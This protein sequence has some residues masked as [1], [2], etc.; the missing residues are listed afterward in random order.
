MNRQM[1]RI[2][3]NAG[4]FIMPSGSFY[5]VDSMYLCNVFTGATWGKL[6]DGEI[7]KLEHLWEN[8]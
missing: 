7:E 6:N 1:F 4:E 5:I 3:T 8:N 2:Q